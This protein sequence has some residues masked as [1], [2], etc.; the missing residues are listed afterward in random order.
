[1]TRREPRAARPRLPRFE[2]VE[3]PPEVMAELVRVT[4]T[5]SPRAAAEDDTRTLIMFK[6]SR[7]L[8]LEQMTASTVKGLFPKLKEP[9]EHETVLHCLNRLARDRRRAVQRQNRPN[10]VTNW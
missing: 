3:L 7:A 5:I 2:P 1:M 6:G 9:V 8:I 10:W 4:E